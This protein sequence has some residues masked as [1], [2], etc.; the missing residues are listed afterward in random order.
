MCEAREWVG[1]SL[2]EHTFSTGY[3]QSMDSGLI[4]SN[5]CYL[6]TIF[7]VGNYYINFLVPTEDYLQT[8]FL[9]LVS[10]LDKVFYFKKFECQVAAHYL[11]LFALLVSTKHFLLY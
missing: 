6:S 2:L 1:R 10:F 9:G 11:P 8:H 7:K 3:K 5:L 4:S